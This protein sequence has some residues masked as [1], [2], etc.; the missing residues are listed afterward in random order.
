MSGQGTTENWSFY[1]QQPPHVDPNTGAETHFQP[2]DPNSPA[3]ISH[4]E[5][6]QLSEMVGIVKGLQQFQTTTV[7]SLTQIEQLQTNTTATL[8]SISDSIAQILAQGTG[9]PPQ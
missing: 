1:D 9:Q 6:V 7:T 5:Y 2:V 8:A 3:T 4:A